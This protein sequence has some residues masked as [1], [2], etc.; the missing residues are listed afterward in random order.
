MPGAASSLLPLY[1]TL[2]Y[3]TLPYLTVNH[4]IML[5]AIGGRQ[6]QVTM[7]RPV[8]AVLIADGLAGA[9]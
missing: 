5:H 7:D 1:L 6:G 9:R 2:P 4:C 3:L 8:A